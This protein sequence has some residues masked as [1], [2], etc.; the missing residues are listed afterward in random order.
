MS[1]WRILLLQMSSR[2]A[3]AATILVLFLTPCLYSDDSLDRGRLLLGQGNHEDAVSA[4]V[5][6]LSDNQNDETYPN[7]VNEITPFIINFAERREYLGKALQAGPEPELRRELLVKLAETEMQSGLLMD[8]QR[9]F[10]EASFAVPGRQDPTS[11]LQSA[12]LAF[13]LGGNKDAEAL[14]RIVIETGRQET[15]KR[16]ARVLLSRVYHATDRIDAAFDL[17]ITGE[18]I[19]EG[20]GVAG[21]YWLYRL[22]SLEGRI[23]LAESARTRLQTDYP[24]ALETSLVEGHADRL[25]S[26]SYVFETLGSRMSEQVIV[27]DTPA[28]SEDIPAI[29]Q[30]DLTRSVSIQT[31]SFTVRENAKYAADDLRSEGFES[32]IEEKVVNGI[33]YF[34]VVVPEVDDDEVDKTILDLKESGFEGYL[35]YD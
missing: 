1:T 9:H 23:A 34:R 35:I 24:E 5:E 31:G 20:I 32:K 22:S 16:N 18:E 30:P 25:P 3:I 4:Y 19:H 13:E 8:A 6:W 7:A 17:L 14:A 26:G 27:T 15:G 10:L 2:V 12:L 29:S 21:L 33:L 28:K 11:L